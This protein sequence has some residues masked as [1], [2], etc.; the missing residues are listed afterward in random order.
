M[1]Q[2]YF[3]H[4]ILCLCL[5]AG[6]TTALAYDAYIDGICYD[7][8]DNGA[9]VV[10]GYDYSGE[11][12]IPS[13]VTYNGMTYSVTSIGSYAFSG[14]TGMTSVT[15]PNSVTSIGES[16]FERCSSMTSVTFG[17]SV[18]SIG[19]C[20]FFDC[21]N[22][23]SI[24]IPESLTSI[25]SCAFSG[26]SGLTSVTIP[27][28]VTS[29][30]N[31]A[32][33]DCSGLTSFTIPGSVTNIGSNAFSGCYF[34]WNK[35]VNN[36]AL[37]S[38]N[39]WGATLCDE[40]TNDGLMIANHAVVLCRPWAT[41]V[42][43]PEGVTSIGKIAFRGCSSLTSVTIPNSVTSIGARTFEYLSSLTSVTIP[44]SVTSIGDYA[45]QNC[46]GLTSVTIPSSVTSIGIDAFSYCGSLTSVTIPSS[47]TSI[48]NNILYACYFQ[49]SK[50][51]DNSTLR[52]DSNWGATL[53][54][55]ET[56]DGLLIA[57]HVVVFCRPWATS[58]N[59][60]NSVTSIGNCAFSG[61]SCL[62]SVTIPNSVTSIGNYA[63]SECSYLT[64]VYCLAEEV[65]ETGSDAFL[66]SP[67]ESA[68]L[69]VPAASLEAYKSTEPWSGFSTIVGLTEDEI[70]AVEDIRTAVE[71][72]EVARYDL[73][74]HR[75]GKSQNGI[76]IIR[77]SDG[78]TR[79]VL[80]K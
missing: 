70:D 8:S 78:T 63:F 33:Q 52:S 54:D 20:A 53:C 41:S 25:G 64:D 4:I 36:S 71:D 34:L 69:Y 77:M 72:T 76:N 15:I 39:K 60:Q 1:K 46:S 57:D 27:N 65:P 11:V 62:T 79:K 26:C 75:I 66:D 67:I 10:S 48:G 43:I 5:L 28:S 23:T 19:Y 59:I 31:N 9:T 68:T 37:T 7:F 49:R 35:F 61:C 55:E 45:F 21:S 56:V 29:I 22:L 2:N 40:E 47:V 14:C 18:T 12:T 24:T 16:V 38:D 73:Q 80:V 32:F 58:V 42:I 44:N 13:I 6:T 3:R 30:G 74:G 17:N 50:F 51:V